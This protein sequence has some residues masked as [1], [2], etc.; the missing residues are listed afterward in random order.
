MSHAVTRVTLFNS[1]SS[2]WLAQS[3][4]KKWGAPPAFDTVEANQGVG[5]IPRNSSPGGRHSQREKR[6]SLWV[7][8]AVGDQWFEQRQFGERRPECPASL[9]RFWQQKQTWTVLFFGIR[10]IRLASTCRHFPDRRPDCGRPSRPGP[11]WAGTWRI[12]LIN[13]RPIP[14]TVNAET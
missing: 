3:P 1:P 9:R 14:A 6:L 10:S 7:P 8:A 13:M 5:V 12:G 11:T 4:P 2:F